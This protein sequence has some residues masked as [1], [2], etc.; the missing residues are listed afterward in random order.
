MTALFSVSSLHPALFCLA[1][2]DQALPW[3]LG[4]ASGS[5]SFL[6]SGT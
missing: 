4:G 3:S 2:S 1:I 5:F 6:E